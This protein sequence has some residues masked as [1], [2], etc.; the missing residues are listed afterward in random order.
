MTEA[1]VV[2]GLGVVAP[3]GLGADDYWRATLSGRSA[4]GRL[5]R[6]DPSRYPSRLA[7]EINGFDPAAH[8]PGRLLP[9]TDQVTRLAL[10][11]SDWAL[12]DA[13][14]DPAR[15]AEY[16][17]GVTTANAYGGFEFGH[18]ELERLWSLGRT[19]VSAYQSF[20]WFYAVN[21]GQI[22]IR[23]GMRGPS[24]VVSAEQAGGLDAVGQARRQ[25]R[26][27]IDVVVT[28]GVESALCPWGWV[29]YMSSDQ[30]SR[31][32]D[33]HRAYLPFARQANGWVPGEGGAILIVER[34]GSARSRGRTPYGIVAGYAAGTD[35]APGSGR[36]P[37]MR[38]VIEQA[39]ADA[40]LTPRE[41]DVVF[42][43]ATGLPEADRREA[44]A[45]TAVFGR[46]A[47]PVTAP[48]TMVGRLAAG[49]SALDTATALLA[50]RDGVI[51]PTVHTSDPAPHCADLDLVLG[52]AREA[53][54]RSALVLARGTGG[55]TSALVLRAPQD[56]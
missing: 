9:Q 39:L 14:A 16:S 45:I 40:R 34:A 49:G 41:V 21:T 18:R 2:T 10:V 26:R 24:G 5:T 50:M 51:P 54:L 46:R 53:P 52:A 23:H 33:P 25:V 27:G 32:Q 15:L 6:F 7:G 19:H 30:I 44:E 37:A 28:G 35:P 22:S 56:A 11:A 29:A 47:V 13:G 55:F 17:M 38:R 8:L 20:A 12:A 3:N 1:A 31:E 43:D 36:P 4:I 48:K 42:A